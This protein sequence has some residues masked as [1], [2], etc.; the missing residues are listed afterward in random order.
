LLKLGW[1]QATQ[2][3]ARL[4]NVQVDVYD[5]AG[6]L[7]DI[8]RPL[9]D[10]QI[11]IP[12]IYTPPPNRAGEMRII[13]SLEVL[14]PRQAVRILHQ[15]R[16]LVNVYDVRCFHGQTVARFDGAANPFYKPE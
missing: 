11:N 12:F 7:F 9:Q 3:K 2:R 10:E 13:M 14:Q 6:L 15:I 1:G 5:R 8:T 4:I 16:A